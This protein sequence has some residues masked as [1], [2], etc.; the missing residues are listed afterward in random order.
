MKS[1]CKNEGER[2]HHPE[3]YAWRR[4]IHCITR[5][6]FLDVLCDPSHNDDLQ[7]E[8]RSSFLFPT[9][10]C[11]R[12]EIAEVSENI[13]RM[14]R[15]P[16]YQTLHVFMIYSITQKNIETSFCVFHSLR[17]ENR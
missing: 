9:Y 15:L 14:T 8:G 6:K 1:T 11:L 17:N 12:V 3:N 5:N 4:Y 13:G 16:H 10:A 2:S 7:V